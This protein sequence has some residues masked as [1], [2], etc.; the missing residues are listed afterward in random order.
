MPQT[1]PKP[2]AGVPVEGKTPLKPDTQLSCVRFSPCGKTLAAAGFDGSI[3]RWSTA[4]LPA[5]LPRLAGHDGWVTA[6]AF[7]PDR[8]RL[9]SADSWGR[10]VCWDHAAVAKL[11]EVPAAHAGWLRKV[12]VSHDGTT[13][14][15][16]GRDGFVRL[17]AA[18][19]GARRA[20]LAADDDLLAL[21]YHPSGALLTG[22]LHG[23][24]RQWDAGGKPGRTF[25][26]KETFKLDRIQEVGGVRCLAFGPAGATLFAGGAEPK[27]GGFVQATPV[28]A[29]FDW[30]T[31]QRT[32]SWKGAGDNEGFVHDLR[33]HP[34]GYAMAV[35]SGQ[36]GQGKVFFWK[37]GDAQPFFAAAKPNCHS[38]DLSPDGATLAVSATN[39]N[40]SGNGR[41]KGVEYAANSS[42]VY[43]WHL[44]PAAPP[45]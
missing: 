3:R 12:A 37:P 7:H 23:R 35:T 4:A 9:F 44:P 45:E 15:T 25:D 6:L 34:A 32:S 24:I 26:A 21:A 43:F 31:G 13:V 42:P 1:K 10:L 5:E 17:W 16:C 38:L 40:S 19:T 39:A 30:A 41:A 11:W 18:D 22:D 14:A 20:E 2:A 29:A 8:V 36:P 27:T 28:V 33:V